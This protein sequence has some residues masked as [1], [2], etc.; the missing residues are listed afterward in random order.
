MS[1]PQAGHRPALDLFS[2]TAALCS[3]LNLRT[4]RAISTRMNVP[5][6]S[7]DIQSQIGS[8]DTRCGGEMKLHIDRTCG[9]TDGRRNHGRKPKKTRS[10]CIYV[11]LPCGAR[12]TACQ[13]GINRI[14]AMVTVKAQWSGS[15]SHLANSFGRRA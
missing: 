12:P 15:R 9:G 6:I 11:T 7:K 2:A 8:D 3:V 14:R 1:Y 10:L 13:G 5:P 4:S